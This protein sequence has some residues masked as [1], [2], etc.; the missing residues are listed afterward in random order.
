MKKGAAFVSD[1]FLTEPWQHHD[2]RNLELCGKPNAGK[3]KVPNGNNI[4]GKRSTHQQS[5]CGEN[6]QNIRLFKDLTVLDNVKVGL[7]Q[8]IILT[9]PYRGN[10]VP[11]LT[12]TRWSGRWTRATSS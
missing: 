5:W 12:H 6:L 8:Q 9:P 3:V 10:P 11:A 4:T 2:L 7:S 1:R